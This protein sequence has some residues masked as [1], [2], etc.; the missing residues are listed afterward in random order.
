[1]EVRI[2]P[3]KESDAYVSVKWRNDPEVFKY[4]GNIYQS[5]I[6]IESELNWIRKVISNSN[7]YRCAIIADGEYVG[8]IYLT[9][10][11]SDEALYHIFIGNKEFH[12]KGV[13]WKASEQI[14][15][16]GF[17]VL[18]LRTIKLAVRPQNIKAIKLYNRLGFQPK[19]EDSDFMYMELE[20]KHA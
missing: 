18:G 5:E 12:G 20:N 17:N 9:N 7:E 19:S 8:N 11:T 14:I 2:R 13:A 1:M 4:T 16:Y 6:T 15:D 10:I 3:L